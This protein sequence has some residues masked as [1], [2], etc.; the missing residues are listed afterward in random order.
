MNRIFLARIFSLS[1][2]VLLFSC[3]NSKRNPLNKLEAVD[4][5]VF[6]G[7]TFRYNEVAYFRSLHPL[8]MDEAVGAR[9]G[10]QIHEGL[11][12]MSPR[13]LTVASAIAEDWIVDSTATVY[14]FKIR[15]GV[16]YHDDACFPNGK[17]REIKAQDFKYCFTKLCE[18]NADNRGFF[19]FENKVVGATAYHE[20]S[21]KGQTLSEGV[22]GVQVLDDYTLE[23][24]LEKPFPGFMYYLSMPYT[25]VFPKEAIEAYGKE[26]RVKPVGSGPF[27]V[28]ELREDEALILVKNENYWGKDQHGNQLPY[29]DAIKITFIKEQKAE[30]LE[31]KKGN[32]D[33]VYRLPLEMYDEIVSKTG[34]LTPSYSDFEL[35]STPSL[36]LN[37][38]G[39]MNLKAP[40]DNKKVRQA[41]NYAIDKQK[42]VNF[43]LKGMAIAAH[44]GTVPPAIVGY[45]AKAVKGYK[46]DADKAKQLLAEAGYKNGEGF[47]E[48]TLQINS[49]GGRHVQ[50]AEAI[51]KMLQDNLNINVKIEALPFPQHLENVDNGRSLFWRLGW[52][53][54]YPD[55]ESFLNLFYSVYAPED[56]SQRAYLN[57][58]RYRSKEYDELFLDAIATLDKDDRNRKY[59]KADQK[60]MDDAPIIPLYYEKSYRLVQPYVKSFYQNPIE[61]RSLRNVFFVQKDENTEPAS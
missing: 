26:F 4:G 47:P 38:Y 59:I 32:L 31:F 58:F 51:Q 17:G 60:I 11:V 3:G 2:I 52:S 43:T 45:D 16:R 37:Y 6:Y 53:A 21:A 48:I 54:D 35:Q 34:E 29:L 12:R 1:L 49:G 18:A 46:Y 40:F 30:L 36:L 8:S 57:T 13:D 39:M 50:M 24:R 22:E 23:I 44:Y 20:A 7:G 56:L 41:F 25:S 33:M 42:I 5:G 15:K 19:L 9:I 55:P 27:R 61:Y 10:Q 14:T 28:K